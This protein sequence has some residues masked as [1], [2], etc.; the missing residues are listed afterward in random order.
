MKV[1]LLNNIVPKAI[2]N[3]IIHELANHHW[4]IAWDSKKSNLEKIF[5]DKNSG[6]SIETLKDGKVN[7]N[8]ILNIYGDFI[9]H[10]ILEK[11]DIKAELHRIFWNMYLKGAEGDYHTDN[12]DPNFISVVYNLHTTDGGTEIDNVL[13]NDLEGQAKIFN[14]NILHKGIGP[15]QNNVRFNLNLVFKN[16]IK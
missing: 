10:I 2:N 1:K 11:L 8:S 6:F 15:K 4:H 3:Q 14:S 7:I 16:V 5:S 13:Y 9:F 12:K